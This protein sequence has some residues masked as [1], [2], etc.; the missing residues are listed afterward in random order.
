M[1]VYKRSI[2]DGLIGVCTRLTAWTLA[3]FDESLEATYYT[4]DRSSFEARLEKHLNDPSHD[5]DPAWYA[6]RNVVFASG[7]R[8][9]TF[10]SHSWTEAQTRS[11]GYFENALAVEADLLHGT[12]GVIAIQ[13]LLAMV[14]LIQNFV[15]NRTNDITGSLRR[16]CWQCKTGIH[17]YQLRSPAGT[18]TGPTSSTSL[19]KDII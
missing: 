9:V 16:R 10:K 2:V 14:S 8:I 5:N 6:L 7:C 3:Y 1:V 18:C 19:I 4:I 12:P 13:A 11:R 15:G 17:A